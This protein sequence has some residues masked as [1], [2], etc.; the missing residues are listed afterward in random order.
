MSKSIFA[1]VD[2]SY[3]SVKPQ[4]KWQQNFVKLQPCTARAV[5]EVPDQKAR[6][7]LVLVANRCIEELVL[8]LDK[9]FT[10]SGN[11]TDVPKI[12]LQVI[13]MTLI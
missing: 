7:W 13:C 2:S 6:S 8:L 4:L 1:P 11:V 5:Q 9:A 12:P 10:L 3:W